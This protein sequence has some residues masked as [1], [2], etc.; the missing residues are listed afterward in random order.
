VTKDE[1]VSR[2]AEKSG[3]PRNEAEAAV[4]AFLASVTDALESGEEV[5]FPGFG[6]FSTQSRNTRKRLREEAAELRAEA[7]ELGREHATFRSNIE[8]SQKALKEIAGT[9]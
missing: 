4:D 8:R 7:E 6:K 1:L 3:L 2:V 5:E 9:S